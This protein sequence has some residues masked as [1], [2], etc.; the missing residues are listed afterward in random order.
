MGMR[1]ILLILVPVL[2]AADRIPIG[3]TAV[4]SPIEVTAASGEGP[5]VLVIGGL[6]G[7]PIEPP[8]PVR[9]LRLLTIPLAN[10]AKARLGFPPTG[11]AYRENGESHYLWRWIGTTAPDLVVITGA[12]DFGLGRALAENAVAGI[13]RIPVRRAMPRP[14]EKIPPSEAHLE[15]ERRLARSPRDV[16]EQL[17]KVYGHELPEVVYIPTM[18]LIGRLRLGERADVERIVAPF[19]SGGKDSLAKPTASHFSGHLIFAELGNT[20]LARR[21]ADLGG[22]S[23]PASLYN[24]MSDG[25]FMGCPILAE[26]GRLTGESKYFDKSLAQLRFMQKLCLR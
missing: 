23:D 1:S 18:A 14:A 25:V 10:P 9:G 17:A 4:G 20:A 3:L 5:T 26:A 13:G 21:A 22:G 24:E 2:I 15:T 7:T 12:D 19:V 8:R 6:D 16:A 11:I